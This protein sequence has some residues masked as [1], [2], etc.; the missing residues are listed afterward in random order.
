MDDIDLIADC[1][2]GLITS[3]N[4]TIRGK[5][6]VTAT[7]W[8]AFS[9]ALAKSFDPALSAPQIEKRIKTMSLT[10]KKEFVTAKARGESYARGS[11]LEDFGGYQMS[12]DVQEGYVGMSARPIE[13]DE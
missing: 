6:E 8:L 1:K 12:F 3:L 10:A 13:A 2:N 5:G 11:G 7:R 4:G 9:R